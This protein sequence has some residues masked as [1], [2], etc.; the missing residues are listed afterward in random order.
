MPLV[1][2]M[3]EAEKAIVRAC[4][5][6]VVLGMMEAREVLSWWMTLDEKARQEFKVFAAS[7]SLYRRRLEDQT[8]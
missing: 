8:V 4:L 5:D 7:V 6:Q 2:R 3:S 1:K